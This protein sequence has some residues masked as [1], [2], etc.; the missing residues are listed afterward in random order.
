MVTLVY[1]FTFGIAKRHLRDIRWNAAKDKVR[2]P[3]VVERREQDALRDFRRRCHMNRLFLPHGRLR[4][5]D[6]MLELSVGRDINELREIELG[7]S[8]RGHHGYVGAY[9]NTRERPHRHCKRCARRSSTFHNKEFAC[10]ARG[11]DGDLAIRF[12]GDNLAD[13]ITSEELILGLAVQ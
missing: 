6:Q 1:S 4:I 2:K 10:Y 7:I 8:L 3:N 5:L 13:V 9:R 12:V 11:N